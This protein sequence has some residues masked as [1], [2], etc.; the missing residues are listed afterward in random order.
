MG[1]VHWT[2][3]M[4]MRGLHS[5]TRPDSRPMAVI[6]RARAGHTHRQ[7]QRKCGKRTKKN[8]KKRTPLSTGPLYPKFEPKTLCIATLWTGVRADIAIKHFAATRSLHPAA[9]HHRHSYIKILNNS[10]ISEFFM[11]FIK[12]R[13]VCAAFWEETPDSGVSALLRSALGTL[14]TQMLIIKLH[15]YTWTT[16]EESLNFHQQFKTKVLLTFMQ[17]NSQFLTPIFGTRPGH[18]FVGSSR[19]G[20]VHVGLYAAL[21]DDHALRQVLRVFVMGQS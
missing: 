18:R 6:Y 16:L 13:S 10:Q 20:G 11:I 5:V 15:I 1:W 21:G 8:C 17:W 14:R 4:Q 3:A 19:E 7:I 9:A 2:I 12:I